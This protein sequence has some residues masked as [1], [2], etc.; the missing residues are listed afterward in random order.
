MNNKKR[1]FAA[2]DLKSFYA[3]VECRERKLDPLDINLVVADESRTS[4]TICL[5][6]SP[7]LKTFGIPGRPRLFEVIKRLQEVNHRREK[8]VGKS[9]GKSYSLE[10]LKKNVKLEVDM[11]VAAPRMKKYMEYSARIISVYLKYVSPEDI[12]VYSVDEVFID[13][14]GYAGDDATG[15][16]EK[17]VKDVLDTTGITA[18]AG[19]GENMYL[20]KIAMDIMAKRAEPNEHGARIGELSVRSYREKL[21]SHTPITDFWRIG[22]GYGKNLAKYGIYT[23]GDIA[24]ESLKKNRANEGMNL[25]YKLFGKNA[26]FLIEHAWGIDN[27]DIKDIKAYTPEKKSIS[28]GQVLL[29]AYSYEEVRTI[30]IEMAERLSFSLL[31]KD[32]ATKQITLSIGYDIDSLAD[33]KTAK[34]YT[35]NITKDFYERSVPEG[36]HGSINFL[37]Y[38]NSTNEICKKSE[39]LFEKLANPILLFRR[40]TIVASEISHKSS[41]GCTGN[42]LEANSISEEKESSRM[43]AVLKVKRKF[44]NNAIFKGL[45]LKEEGTALDRNRQIGGHRE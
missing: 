41:A 8:L 43:K 7:A 26:S 35:G 22:R 13:I 45:N 1:I 28:E 32:T 25:L 33:P 14:T 39:E 37:S 40:I 18:S 19:I 44:G 4:K 27:T 42:L 16:V 9:E 2:I 3:S 6:V 21:W 10:E 11:V 24:R 23:M 29:R 30:V 12:Y 15:F 34:N 17:M 5:A 20:A 36:A 31:E 38:T